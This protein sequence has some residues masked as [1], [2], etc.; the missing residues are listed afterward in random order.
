[1]YSLHYRH[2]ADA[3]I[4]SDLHNIYTAFTLRPCIQLDMY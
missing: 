3:L 4:L 2:L 1:M